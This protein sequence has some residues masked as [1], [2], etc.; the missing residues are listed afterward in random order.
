MGV[1]FLFFPF[2]F[3][4][5]EGGSLAI[6]P[7]QYLATICNIKIEIFQNGKKLTKKYPRNRNCIKM[8]Q[9]FLKYFFSSEVWQ[10]FVCINKQGVFGK[11]FLSIFCRQNF[12]KIFQREN[13]GRY[14]YQ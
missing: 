9:Q 11:I 12:A 13:I 4:F 6:H 5:S 7:K 3:Q 10:I 2:F 8:C 1:L 14:C